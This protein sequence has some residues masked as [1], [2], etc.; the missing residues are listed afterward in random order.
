MTTPIDRRRMRR[1]EQQFEAVRAAFLDDR[2]GPGIEVACHTDADGFPDFYHQDDAILVHDDHVE[3]ARRRLRAEPDDRR[4]DRAGNGHTLVRLREQRA[5]EAVRLMRDEGG[6]GAARFN[7]ILSVA[8]RGGGNLCPADE[9]TVPADVTPTP[10]VGQG[11]GAGEGVRV[12]VIDTG[13]VEDAATAH[14]WLAGVITGPDRAGRWD[15]STAYR[16]HGTFIAGVVRCMAPQAEVVV[17]GVFTRAGATW[18]TDLVRKLDEALA[19]SPDIISLSAGT[20]SRQDVSTLGLDVFVEERLSRL[21]GVVLVAAAGNDGD[22]GPFF[23]AAMPEVVSVGALAANRRARAS[24]SNH[25]GWVDVYAPGEHLVNAY[26]TGNFTCEEPP[27]TGQVRT[28]AGMCRWSGTSFS[29]PLVSGL[30]AARMSVTGENGRQAADAL[31]RYARRHA[32]PGVG[33]V[34]LPGDACASVHRRKPRG[35]LFGLAGL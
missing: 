26:L 11:D 16:G 5:A 12:R 18:E 32:I 29:T 15:E 20:R 17:K 21:K 10:R 13:L 19:E 8:S 14:P 33:A 27:N 1:F 31:L 7:H 24:F 23:P 30:I 22:R 35:C 6:P 9:P 4:Q 34:L 2:D 25:G 3:H 28:F